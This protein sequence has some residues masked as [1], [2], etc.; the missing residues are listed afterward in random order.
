MEEISL[1]LISDIDE[2]YIKYSLLYEKY[3]KKEVE[4]L[5]KICK[6]SIESL[7]DAKTLL[8]KS[9]VKNKFRNIKKEK[10]NHP[11]ISLSKYH[12]PGELCY[13]CNEP[14]KEHFFNKDGKKSHS[15]TKDY[16]SVLVN[17][18]EKKKE[19]KKKRRN[20]ET[21][22]NMTKAIISKY[23][24]LCDICLEEDKNDFITF[25]CGHQFCKDCITSLFT[26]EIKIGK[27][28]IKCPQKECE[29]Y[30]DEVIVRQNVNF[31]IFQKYLKFLRRKEIEKIPG[32]IPC[33]IPDCESYALRPEK[34]DNQVADI[35]LEKN[36]IINIK[37][38]NDEGN[39]HNKYL[40][41][42]NINGVNDE[43][44][45]KEDDKPI[46]LKCLDNN[47][48]FC[49]KCLLPPHPGLQCNLNVEKNYDRWK[50]NNDVQ[51]CPKCGIEILK[52]SGC[53]HMTC[54][55]CKYQFCWICRGQYS[56]NHFDNP[57]SPC[58]HMQYSSAKSVW[59]TNCFL[60]IIKYIGVVILFFT[61]LGLA[62]CLPGL[63][64]VCGVAFFMYD[65]RIIDG[66][67]GG[68]TLFCLGIALNFMGYIII[69]GAIMVSPAGI[70]YYCLTEYGDDD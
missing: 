51:K 29:I 67:L 20:S 47:H 48:E 19:K 39:K 14:F 63:I 40:G 28:P 31:D 61:L 15:L 38:D 41:E 1:N 64:M 60:R 23:I 3:D 21:K 62:L 25:L 18:D 2:N 70:I 12:S 50:N 56:S 34:S 58:F 59:A 27:V 26:E 33:P 32:A 54:S 10:I 43:I 44:N 52:T 45:L 5:L 53:N 46:I 49:S 42:K 68:M 16:K 22:T 13:I 24:R 65:E 11:Y 57:F 35:S 30:I 9:E 36:I 8:S 37:D 7:D 66:I 55:K 69:A 6:P 4:R 17:D